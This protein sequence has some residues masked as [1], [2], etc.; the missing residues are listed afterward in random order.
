MLSGVRARIPSNDLESFVRWIPTLRDKAGSLAMSRFPARVEHLHARGPLQ[1]VSLTREVA[2]AAVQVLN[3]ASRINSFIGMR[4]EFE[5]AL[6]RGNGLRC[7]QILDMLES[8]LGYSFW[9][10]E[11]RI[12]TLQTFEGLEA[13]KNYVSQL[14]GLL[15][16]NN[17]VSFIVHHMSRRC[18]PSTVP[19]RFVVG[20][21]AMTARW[22]DETG[23]TDYVNFRV[24]NLLTH[25]ERSFA[26]LLRVDTAGTIIDLYETLVVLAKT[27]VVDAHELSIAFDPWISRLTRSIQDQR[28]AKI[29]VMNGETESLELLQFASDVASDLVLGGQL[30]EAAAKLAECYEDSPN[31]PALW[32]AR[33]T[34][35]ESLGKQI[36][37]TLSPA[38]TA[39]H[40]LVTLI[41]ET[42]EGDQAVIHLFRLA[43]S[44]R[45]LS[46]AQS[47]LLYAHQ[48]LSTQTKTIQSL[49]KIAF[50]D[51]VGTRPGDV[52]LLPESLRQPFIE[53][54]VELSTQHIATKRAA[55]V[56]SMGSNVADLSQEEAFRARVDA[57]LLRDD[58]QAALDL[59]L[60][61]TMKPELEESRWAIRRAARSMVH[62]QDYVS[63]A[64]FL[65]MHVTA[66][67]GL[68]RSL[69][70]TDCVAG[71]TDENKYHLK[72]ELTLPIIL[73]LA[74]QKNDDAS[75]DARSFAYEDFLI[76]NGLERPSQLRQLSSKFEPALLVFYLR[77]IC[78]P[79]VMQVSSEFQS[80]RELQDERI[81]VLRLLVELDQDNAKTYEDELRERA[82]SLLVHSG[83]RHIGQTK[84][85][86]DVPALHRWAELNLIEDF[87]RLHSYL[88]VGLGIDHELFSANLEQMARGGAVPPSML[89]IPK[90]EATDLFLKM[91]SSLLH[92]FLANPDH[93][94]DCYLSMRI[95]HGTL[96]GQ[97]RTP[98]EVEHLITQRRAFKEEYTSNEHWREIL[99]KYDVDFTHIDARLAQ[100]SAEYD[101]LIAEILSELIQ[102]RSNEKPNGLFDF[103]IKSG[104]IIIY[105]TSLTSRLTFDEF[106]DSCFELF[107]EYVDRGLTTVRNVCNDRLKTTVRKIFASLEADLAPLAGSARAD[108]ERAIRSSSTGAQQAL[109]IV[110]D[111]FRLPTPIEEPDFPIEAMIDVGLKCVTTIYPDF[112][113]VLN[114]QV[115]ILPPFRGALALFSDIFFIVFDNIRR[116][117][118]L[119]RPEVDLI[120][121]D[122]TKRLRI[123]VDSDLADGINIEVIKARLAVIRERI[124][125]DDYQS[126]V[127]SE[128]GTGLIKLHRVL[129]GRGQRDGRLAFGIE[130]ERFFVDIDLGIREI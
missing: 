66:R 64:R 128:G 130:G 31:D 14:R 118:G 77:H 43:L 109:D 72:K 19:F 27:A 96:S 97:M 82:R 117:S 100:F 18:E 45:S 102:I 46:F 78:V 40:Y 73:H 93:G 85:F 126:A 65:A 68:V 58:E 122:L 62:L 47:I 2:W 53:R 95:R 6:C 4:S 121:D 57:Y 86:V 16:D 103:G 113:P 123:R 111:W 12:A 70:V 55:F 80:T 94:L 37:V 44:F 25:D 124:A 11:A 1:P 52:D 48:S 105:L 5:Q 116:H 89:E 17:I 63:L 88:E 115:P 107:W 15:P 3:E 75:T 79:E 8:S 127:T 110:A 36:P 35:A 56:V 106:L 83:V 22:K 30:S 98:L 21:A 39:S 51:R 38:D 29:A 61:A 10:I 104:R 24:A 49:S 90:N 114:S 119:T 20:F 9:S 13:Q 69:P 99:A 108:L 125:S 50:I 101:T 120:I 129:R 60:A 7:I 33:A 87:A 112:H 34:V 92:E 26:N 91:L 28:L 76:A 41:G 67:P 81:A 74:V 84:I 59:L 54:A 71:L 42:I 32:L 23:L